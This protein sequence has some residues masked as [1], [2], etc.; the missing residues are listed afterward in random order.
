MYKNYTEPLCWSDGRM[1]KILLIMKL[2][3][4]LLI[5]SIMQ[6]SANSFAQRITFKQNNV[7][8]ETL[9]KE[10]RKQTGYNVLWLGINV[11]ETKKI[12]AYFINSSIDEV[13]MKSLEHQSLSFEIDDRTIIIKK[14]EPSFLDRVVSAFLTIDIKGVVVDTQGNVL[15]GA[16]IKV[17]GS[18]RVAITNNLGEFSIRNV[19]E[20]AILEISYL[21]YRVK[22]AKVAK[23]LG[24]I[25]LEASS[26]ELTE[27]FVVSTGYQSLP[28]ERSA[29]SFSQVSGDKLREKS[30]SLNVVDRLE[31]MVPGL[32]VNY[33]QGNDKLLLRG[34][35]SVNLGREP[36]IILDGIPVAEYRNI[37]SLVNPQDVKDI[38]VLKDA[39]AA[40]IWGAQAA[41]GVIVITT[42]SGTY[43]SG[44]ININYDGFVSFKGSPEYNSLNLM[45]GNEF[46][47]ASKQLFADNDYLTAFPYNMVST[48]NFP[49]IY[50]HEQIFY[51]LKSGLN[52]QAVANQRWDSL[53]N[54]S[55]RGQID[56]NFYQP[57]MLN[58]HSVTLSGGSHVNKYFGS[59]S[60]NRY[61]N[62]DKSTRDR[63]SFNLREEWKLAKWLTLDLTGNMS[64][65]KNKVLNMSYPMALDEYLPY[66][67]FA[68][69]KGNSLSHSYLYMTTAYRNIA[70]GKS[71]LNLDYV[72]LN[73]LNYND[74][75]NSV[76]AAR[77]NAGIKID[78]L[79][80]LSFTTR[81]QYQKTVDDGYNF[82][83]DDAYRVR[84]E[85][86]KFTQSPA[87]AGGDPVYFL[88]INGGHYYTNKLNVTAQTIRNQLDYNVAIGDHQ[89]TALAGQEVRSTL[90]DVTNT[91]T[92]GY[93][94]QTQTYAA[95]NQKDLELTGV[96]NP[97]LP[98]G[99]AAKNTL[100]SL[101]ITRAE[102][103][104]RFVSFY[105]NLAYAY[106]NKYIFN[107]SL[108][109]DQSNLFGTSK[110]SQNKPIW[111]TGVSWNINREDFFDTSIFSKLMLRATYGISG[112]SPKPGLGGTA[113]VLYANNNAFYNGLGT[114]YIIISPGNDQLVWEKTTALNL[115]IDFEVFSQ[116]ISGSIDYYNKQTS[117]LLGDR[118]LDPTTGWYSA[119]G[120]LGE[121]YN[122]GVEL[123][124]NSRN[125]IQKDFSWTTN[126]NIAY[127]KNKI[128]SLKRYN[129][130][131]VGAKVDGGFI[132]GYSAYSLFAYQ[133]AGLN[134]D[135][136]P[137]VYKQDGNTAMFSNQLTLADAYYKGSTQ[138]LW[139]G[140]MTNTFRYKDFS[141]SGLIV[142]NL[143]HVMRS[144]VNQFYSGRL[145]K[146]IQSNFNE[147]WMGPGDET[148]TIVPKYIP[149]ETQSN[150]QRTTTF[151]TKSDANIISASYVR[152]RDLTLAYDL[153]QNG[154]S[155]LNM[156]GARV[157]FQMNNLLLWRQNDQK[158]DPEYY[159]LSSGTRIK[160]MPAFYTIGL[161]LS[162]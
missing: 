105:G 59:L 61:D 72:P 98:D 120:N 75:K 155:K 47:T 51:D 56:A 102:S 83:N 121:L 103:E 127:N 128:T 136:N 140:G 40:S 158:I 161:N 90:F 55:N 28:K 110:S 62:A 22:E 19:D 50:P 30:G 85:K 25:A 2:V 119:Y 67:L 35:S 36:L 48:G 142:Y 33:G 3:L 125:V 79:K 116:R 107:G 87:T 111:S 46:I 1:P 145:L 150:N 24:K 141:L 135:G 106:K 9:F 12:N 78:L 45:S 4:V 130:L 15:V 18:N 88:P 60:Y 11:K 84:L 76:L 126:F 151:F 73:E 31:G 115:G 146:N 132:E 160:A 52:T 94:F 20:Q 39:T 7:S 54:I 5:A 26:D 137:T 66:A 114:G 49:K 68:D 134:A 162:F 37:E 17:K 16:T 38:T 21:G 23:D 6:V 138:P 77:V 10:L 100:R 53:A 14:K 122:K 143:G 156:Q 13:L 89:I 159:S 157:Y 74:N 80:G 112:N 64:Y 65:E 81:A 118:P 99:T 131:S 133:Y 101:P 41:N 97:V 91:L 148:R 154:L 109:Y 129:T 29:G 27:V 95:Y 144:D 147:R 63:Y 124:I 153:F 70:E 58:S 152:L 71:K 69:E 8:L 44:K 86:V 117:D 123:S 139:Y 92:R 104:L 96:S 149:N 108:R 82:Y 93:D 113:D 57:A 34:V 43:N 32:A 42:K